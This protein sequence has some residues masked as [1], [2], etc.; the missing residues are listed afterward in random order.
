MTRLI[1]YYRT[2]GLVGSFK[3]IQERIWIDY[4]CRNE[5][6]Y[7]VDLQ[8][9]HIPVPEIPPQYTVVE[10]IS[11]DE[12]T[13]T[14]LETFLHYREEKWVKPHHKERFEKGATLWIVNSGGKPCGFVWSVKG[15]TIGSHYFIFTENDTHL[16]D[17]EIFHDFRGQGINTYLLLSVLHRLKAGGTDRVHIETKVKNV[18][19]RFSLRKTPFIPYAVASKVRIPGHSIVCWRGYDVRDDLPPL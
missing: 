3:R 13:N 1:Q 9:A 17:N 10:R 14:E 19:E 16:F 15:R 12:I 11:Q 5:V 7:S 4:F 6:L 2:N 8:H 18:P